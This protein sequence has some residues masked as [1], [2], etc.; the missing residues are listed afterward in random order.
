MSRRLSQ[1]ADRDISL[2]R[3]ICS[4]SGHSGLWQADRPADL[5]VHGLV[6]MRR[7]GLL[8]NSKTAQR[9]AHDLKA[10]G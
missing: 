10:A 3:R 6:F 4:L 1:T 9:L 5:W 7:A 2:R 8:D